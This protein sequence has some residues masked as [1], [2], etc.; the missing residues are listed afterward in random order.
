MY[1]LTHNNHFKFGYD[2]EWFR[3]R[4]SPD[5]QWMASYGAC[6]RPVGDFRDECYAT[7]RLIRDSFTGPLTVMFSG[8]ADSEIVLR[9]FHDQG[10]PTKV[11]ICQFANNLNIHD[12]SYAVVCCQ[13]LDIPFDLIP[14]DIAKFLDGAFWPY[15]EATQSRSPELCSTMWLADQV[16]GVP[17]MGSGEC[18]LV[19]RIKATYVD[20]ESPYETTPWDMYERELIAGWYRHFM[21]P[22]HERQAVPGFFQY[23]PEVMLSFLKDDRVV[24]L[25][26]DRIIGKRSTITSKL[27][28]YQKY[29][30][31]A[32]RKKFSGY[33][34]VTDRVT[35]AR[36]QLRRHMPNTGGMWLTEY[37]DLLAMLEGRIDGPKGLSFE[38]IYP[39]RPVPPPR[40]AAPHIDETRQLCLDDYEQ[41]VELIEERLSTMIEFDRAKH[42]T[43]I[44][45]K[46]LD[47]AHVL[48]RWRSLIADYYLFSE[49]YKMFGSFKDGRLMSMVGMRL[50]FDNAWV[51]ANLKA[52]NVPLSQTGLKP[53][54]QMLYQHAKDLGLKEY[55]CSFAEYRYEKFQKLIDKLVPEYYRDYEADILAVIPAGERPEKEF[56]WRMMG[57]SVSEV[58][59]VIKRMRNVKL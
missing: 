35:A 5:E 22:G 45:V 53:T 16:D 30:P 12:V 56:W 44:Q 6:Q 39:H 20:G 19:K 25:A 31:L 42:K 18:Y 24:D 33:E 52:R 27:G 32:D 36:V 29:F 51:L 10:I 2:H 59:V 40:G 38:T 26:H 13:Q 1:P 11:A 7:A 9:S 34:K 37:H 17:V 14:L 43:F 21:R 47:R 46:E 8:G 4:Q 57:A 58:N 23:T 28:I 54:L 49:S 48:K 15:A 55:Y 50:V 3:F 41:V